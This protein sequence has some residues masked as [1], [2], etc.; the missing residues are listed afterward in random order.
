[1]MLIVLRSVL[2]IC[3]LVMA[4]CYVLKLKALLVLRLFI[5]WVKKSP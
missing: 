4:V 2:L 3:G 5:D 1:M